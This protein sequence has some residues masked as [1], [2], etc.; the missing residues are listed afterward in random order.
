MG[1]TVTV[2]SPPFCILQILKDLVCINIH[3]YDLF[4]IF[5]VTTRSS[6]L[7]DMEDRELRDAARRCIE[8][9]MRVKLLSELVRRDVGLK[10]VEEFV[11][12][13]RGKLREKL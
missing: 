8:E 13:E 12:K 6:S 4:H 7:V 11:K 9:E 2:K 1:D 3:I 5:E 10:E